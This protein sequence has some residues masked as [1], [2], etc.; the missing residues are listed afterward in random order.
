VRWRHSTTGPRRLWPGI[1]QAYGAHGQLWSGRSEALAQAPRMGAAAQRITAK[2]QENFRNAAPSQD[3]FLVAL[4]RRV[5]NF[6]QSGGPDAQGVG[7]V[8]E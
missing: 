2:L 4:Q 6:L 7:G 1:L 5:W 8:L 3:T